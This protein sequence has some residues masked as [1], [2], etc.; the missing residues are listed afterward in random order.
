MADTTL[1]QNGRRHQLHQQRVPL[2][3]ERASPVDER[4]MPRS[5]IISFLAISLWFPL[6]GLSIPYFLFIVGP[7]TLDSPG[8]GILMFSILYVPLLVAFGAGLYS[9]KV[10]GFSVR[11]LL[12]IIG[13]L[14]SIIVTTLMLM[15]S[16]L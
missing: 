5:S 12:G 9:L 16:N 3:Y 7:H 13:L 8:I 6:I 10:A 1:A 4:R 11:N 2:E 14:N 15:D